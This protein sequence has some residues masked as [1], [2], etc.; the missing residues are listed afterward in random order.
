MAMARSTFTE[1]YGWRLRPWSRLSYHGFMAD[2]QGSGTTARDDGILVVAFAAEHVIRLTGLSMRQLAYWDRTGFFRPQYALGEDDTVSSRVYSFKD[3][4]GLRTLGLLRSVHRVSLLHL[5]TV[6][7]KLAALSETPWA[8]IRLK[9]WNRKVQ[10][11]E[12]GT[13]KTVGVVDGQYLL[14]P[15]IDVMA[16]IKDR[17]SRLMR[18]DHADFGQMEKHR[19]VSHNA[20]VIAGT[21]IRV[22]TILHFHEAGYSVEQI[23]KEYPSLTA[24]DVRAAIERGPSL[25]AA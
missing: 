24:Q 15:I 9:V 12:P 5:R 7:E 6:A 21:R 18:R 22:S 2:D 1:P 23:V 10:F 14:L 11:D 16:E 19:S 8:D 25:L 4:V 3:V 13:G 17:A 20:L